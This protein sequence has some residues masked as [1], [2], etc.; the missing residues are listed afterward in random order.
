MEPGS[1]HVYVLGL[2]YPICN[3]FRNSKQ[4]SSR[5]THVFF[6]Q[7]VGFLFVCCFVFLSGFFS[8]VW[9]NWSTWSSSAGEAKDGTNFA[10]VTAAEDQAHELSSNVILPGIEQELVEKNEDTFENFLAVEVVIVRLCSCS[11]KKNCWPWTHCPVTELQW[12]K[13]DLPEP[14]HGSKRIFIEPLC[15]F[16]CCPLP[17]GC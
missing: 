9:G 7:L 6:C 2:W 1:S 8:F 5:S 15:V 13:L 17:S 16:G 10:A 14:G 4:V 3:F 12:C 11:S